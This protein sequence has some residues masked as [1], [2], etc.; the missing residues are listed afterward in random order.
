MTS[1]VIGHTLGPGNPDEG[2]QKLFFDAKNPQSHSVTV[3]GLKEEGR[4][5]GSQP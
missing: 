2:E 1:V 5:N 4:W 3:D